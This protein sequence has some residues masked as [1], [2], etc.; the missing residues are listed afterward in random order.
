VYP[1]IETAV[2]EIVERA[3][4]EVELQIARQTLRVQRCS[5]RKAKQIAGDCLLV[6]EQSLET[7]M[8]TRRRFYARR[9]RYEA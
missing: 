3:I 5:T 7:L 1:E 6:L 2:I 4:V 9:V 8:E